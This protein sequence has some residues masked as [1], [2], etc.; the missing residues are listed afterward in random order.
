[1]R[2]RLLLVLDEPEQ[3]LDVEGVAWLGERLLREKAT[4]CG[5]LLVSHDPALV[6]RVCDRVLRLGQAPE[7][8]DVRP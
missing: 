1:M 6:E 3:R 5:V 8:D 7:I 2:P 4:G